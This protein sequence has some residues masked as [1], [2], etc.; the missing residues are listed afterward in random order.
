MPESLKVSL[1]EMS[2]K[3]RN[4]VWLNTADI[5]CQMW[6]Y[7]AHSR[8]KTFNALKIVLCWRSVAALCDLNSQRPHC[9]TLHRCCRRISSSDRP[10]CYVTISKFR[11]SND[12]S[13]IFRP[14]SRFQ[15]N[16]ILVTHTLNHSHQNSVEL[17]SINR[18]RTPGAVFNASY[19]C[20]G[21][22]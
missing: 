3:G 6:I 21:P 16:S 4:R 15:Y 5:K 12:F 8:K 13:S 20:T 22:C 1:W 10:T 14:K 18:Q 7:I 2:S 19:F 17:N 11:F 9:P